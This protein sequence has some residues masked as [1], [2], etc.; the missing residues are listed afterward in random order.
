MLSTAARLVAAAAAVSFVAPAALGW[1][2]HGH[3]VITL[4]ALDRLPADAPAWMRDDAVRAMIAEQS[5]EADRWRSTKAIPIGHEVSP[6]HY[7]DIEDLEPFGLK[8]RELSPYRYEAFRAMVLAKAANP[9]AFPA[10]EKDNDKTKE[11]P[12]F[13]PWAIQEHAAQLQASMLTYRVLAAIEGRARPEDLELARQNIIH[14]MGMMAH[15]VGDAAQPLHTTR[16]HHGWIGD[17]P[18]GYTTENGF[19]SYIDSGVVSL[20]KLDYAGLKPLMPAASTGGEKDYWVVGLG[21]IERSF[22]HVEPLYVMEKDGTLKQDPG[23]AVIAE[24]LCDAGATLG[25]LYSMAW[26]AAAPTERDIRTFIK[27]SERGRE[28]EQGAADEKEP[29]PAPSPAAAK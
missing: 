14:Q 29:A 28:L 21:A 7:I 1:G 13:L 26:E 25:Q 6:E 16:H 20:H 24:R 12:G 22:A 19:H 17:N 18:N 5:N 2:A 11:W 4:L 15:F 23:R 27:F 8:L 10:V 3:R 9:S